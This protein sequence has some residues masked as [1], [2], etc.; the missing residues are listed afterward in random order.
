MRPFNDAIS[1]P[2]ETITL[3]VLPGVDYAPSVPSATTIVLVS[4][5]K[6]HKA[7]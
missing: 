2:P 4:V 6:K 7:K 1:E 5:D 3:A